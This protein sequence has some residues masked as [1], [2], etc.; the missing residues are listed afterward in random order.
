MLVPDAMLLLQWNDLGQT[1]K[2]VS[3]KYTEP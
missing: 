1:I 2:S 3:F